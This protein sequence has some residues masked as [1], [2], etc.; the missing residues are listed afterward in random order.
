MLVIFLV[1]GR[2][3]INTPRCTSQT[4]VNACGENTTFAA[5][6]RNSQLVRLH[7]T[8]LYCTVGSCG[9]PVGLSDVYSDGQENEG[10]GNGPVAEVPAMPEVLEGLPVNWK[11]VLA[12]SFHGS[13]KE[14]LKGK[15]FTASW[16]MTVDI[17][18]G[19]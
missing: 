3:K 2:A 14:N 9:L 13:E 10:L 11:R 6:R 15:Y 1:W 8:L 17:L 5:L 16:T 7:S 18:R 12:A 19:S 4:D